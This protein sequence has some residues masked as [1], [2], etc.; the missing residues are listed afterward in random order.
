MRAG[1]LKIVDRHRQDA[2]NTRD[3]DEIDAYAERRP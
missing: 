2:G 3:E 1:T